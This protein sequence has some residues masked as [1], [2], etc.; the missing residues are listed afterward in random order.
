MGFHFGSFCTTPRYSSTVPFSLLPQLFW[1]LFLFFCIIAF[2][3]S[4]STRY[5]RPHTLLLSVYSCRLWIMRCFKSS[6]F[7]RSSLSVQFSKYTGAE[8]LEP[9]V[10]VWEQEKGRQQSCWMERQ[11]LKNFFSSFYFSISHPP[12]SSRK[13]RH[14]KVLS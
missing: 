10:F 7:S 11:S 5:T 8:C 2:L 9:L 3:P 13:T 12:T 6:I 1:L 14:E 4:F